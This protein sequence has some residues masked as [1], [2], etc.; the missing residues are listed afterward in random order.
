MLD[1]MDAHRSFTDRG[2]AFHHFQVRDCRINRRLIL[3][4]FAPEL[5]SVI[6]R[7]GVKFQRD[8]FA[9]VQRSAAKTAG[10]AEGMLKLGRGRHK[11][12][13]NRDF[14]VWPDVVGR[15]D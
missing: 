2:C 10:L 9:C 1:G 7:R 6:H 4:I 13:S 12:L 15:L 3:E 11:P 14:V 8:L 5:D